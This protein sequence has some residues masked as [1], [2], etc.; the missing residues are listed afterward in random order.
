M[1]FEI[2]E[3]R[4]GGLLLRAH[5]EADADAVY[6]RSIDPLTIEWTTVPLEY[7]HQMAL[8]FIATVARPRRDMIVW[9]LDVDGACAGTLDLRWHGA[10]VGSL[11]FATSPAFRGQGLMSRAVG[12]A[13]DHAFGPL[14]WQEVGWSANPGNVGSYKTV[15]RN[16]F[17]LPVLVPG[18]ISHRGSRI[19]GWT[20]SITAGAPR[21]PRLPWEQAQELLLGN[22]LE[23][24]PARPPWAG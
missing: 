12:L 8:D 4:D 14:G 13:L 24:S 17:P 19:D 1:P 2:P 6:A 11:G 3:L 10:G 18:L 21:A 20:S 16:G 9:A 15:W 5:T 7:T 23:P 22:A